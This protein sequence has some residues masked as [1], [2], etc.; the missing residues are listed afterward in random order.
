MW[1]LVY[2]QN[3]ENAFENVGSMLGNDVEKTYLGFNDIDFSEYSSK[4]IQPIRSENMVFTSY[5]Q[6]PIFIIH[7][8][9]RIV[10]VILLLCMH[11]VLN[12]EDM[13]N[14]PHLCSPCFAVMVGSG[15]V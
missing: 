12:L 1:I 8:C 5:L 7:G 10:T 14:F 2:V 6:F 3:F 15:V 11:K 9:I 4:K 13:P